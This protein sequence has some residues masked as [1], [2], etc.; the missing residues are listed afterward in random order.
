MSSF[1]IRTL[2]V[3]LLGWCRS[4]FRW[5]RSCESSPLFPNFGG[6]HCLHLHDKSV[7]WAC[8]W[9]MIHIEGWHRWGEPTGTRGP[10]KD[11]RANIFHWVTLCN[12]YNFPARFNLMSER[13]RLHAA[14]KYWQHNHFHKVLWFKNSVTVTFKHIWEPKT[15]NHLVD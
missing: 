14:S 3:I 12:M 8:M 6:T 5:W 10:S 1:V 13:W 9:Y 4:W 11:V 7:S 15:S 2:C